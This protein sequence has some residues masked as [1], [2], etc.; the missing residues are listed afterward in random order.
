MIQ[1]IK[2]QLQIKRLELK[3]NFL[4]VYTVSYNNH[5]REIDENCLFLSEII[6]LHQVE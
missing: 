5:L 1:M 6:N 3:Q 4:S 2:Q